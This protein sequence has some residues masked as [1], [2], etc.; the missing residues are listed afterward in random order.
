[1]SASAPAFGY[2]ADERLDPSVIA[3]QFQNLVHDGTV[4]PLQLVGERAREALVRT[5]FDIDA[6]HTIW[7]GLGP[8]CR[9]P[10]ERHQRHGTPVAGKS[11]A[12]RYFC[13]N[14]NSRVF[15]VVPGNEEHLVVAPHVHR[16]RDR[17]ARKHHRVVQRNDSQLVHS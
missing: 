1:M 16:Q 3:A 8:A 10:M 15:V 13:D 7:P 6:Q 2:G 5:G 12:L 9:G 4:L 11:H 14:A 17:H